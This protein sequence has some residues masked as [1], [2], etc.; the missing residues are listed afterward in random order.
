MK[1]LLGYLEDGLGFFMCK[2]TWLELVDRSG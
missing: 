1:D 2:R